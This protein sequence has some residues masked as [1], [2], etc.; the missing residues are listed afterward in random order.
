LLHNAIKY[1]PVDGVL[2]V[3]LEVKDQFA[4]LTIQDSGKGIS[5]ELQERL[6]QPFSAGDIRTGSGL[7]LAICL[8]VVKALKGTITLTN[9]YEN[10]TVVGLDTVVQLP[11]QNHRSNTSHTNTS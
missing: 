2:S 5:P 6:F 3:W 1:S 11:L 10:K 4:Q 8:E 9:R 7:G